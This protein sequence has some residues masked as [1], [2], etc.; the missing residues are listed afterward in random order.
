[1]L[2]LVKE[3]E[4]SYDPLC[5]TAWE[6]ALAFLGSEMAQSCFWYQ[7]SR[8]TRLDINVHANSCKISNFDPSCHYSCLETLS[9]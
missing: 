4:P 8:V 3:P 2:D 5:V 7:R 1:M 9:T 6:E